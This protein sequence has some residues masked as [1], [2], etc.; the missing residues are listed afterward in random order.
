MDAILTSRSLPE[1]HPGANDLVG[2]ANHRIANSLSVLV[3]MV[4]MQSASLKKGAESFSNAEI[5]HLL[6]GIAARINTISQLHRILARSGGD[7]VISLRP[8]LRE[9]TDALVAALSSPEQQAVKVMHTGCDCM[10]QM[11]QVQPIVLMLC[12]VFINAIKYAH[13]SGVP[14]IMLVD[15]SVSGDGRLV[16]TISDDGVGLPEGF[17]PMQSGGMGFKV[18][19]SLAAEVGGELQIQSTHLGLSFRL[20]MPAMAMAGAKLA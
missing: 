10:V 5:R 20:S 14:L 9:V 8:H 17:E 7:G 13:P 2:E 3:G 4:R 19:R 11:R 1:Q 16:L 12:E 6:D 18:M 15:C